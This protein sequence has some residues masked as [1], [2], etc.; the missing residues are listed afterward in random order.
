MNNKELFLP[1]CTVMLLFQTFWT[2]N[3]P[4]QTWNSLLFR[5]EWWIGVVSWIWLIGA[6]AAL[7]MWISF[8]VTGK[9]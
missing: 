2:M 9:L 7:I 6:N 3:Y 8:I 5:D 1:L 4:R